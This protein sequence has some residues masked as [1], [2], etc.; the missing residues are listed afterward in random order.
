MGSNKNPVSESA[1][2]CLSSSLQECSPVTQATSV[3][4]PTDTCLSRG[5]VVKDGDD[6][7]QVSS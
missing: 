1:E 3:R 6:L 5:V 2:I 7:G 4:F